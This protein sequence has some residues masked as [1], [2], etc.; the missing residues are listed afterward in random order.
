MTKIGIIGGSGLEKLDI[1]RAKKEIA[2]TTEYGKPSSTFFTSSIAGNEV[3]I[4]SRHDRDHSIPPSQI[5]N[6]ANIKGFQDLGC[7]YIIS[8]AACGSLREDIKP[9]DLVIPDQFI[10]FTRFRKNTFFD[11]FAHGNVKHTAM[12]DP[13]SPFLREKLKDCCLDLSLPV[14]ME[15]TIITIE[16][17][18]FSTRA[19]SRMYRVL[20]ADLVNM[21][22]APEAI[23]ANE[24]G[25]P[26]A[27]IAMSTDYDSWH[28]HEEAVSWAKIVEIFEKNAQNITRVIADL[29][30]GF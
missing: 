13:F 29:L 27:C 11:S 3:Y 17:P 5:N 4:L 9:G 2:L 24:A 16:G 6:L 26:Y 7:E 25:I 1:F 10:D 8:T 30:L 18:R 22:T 28:E 14:K 12:A 20:G 23:L 21:S 15:G 19:E